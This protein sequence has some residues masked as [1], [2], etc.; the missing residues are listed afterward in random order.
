MAKSFTRS[1]NLRNLLSKTGCPETI[2]RCKSVFH[3]LI[4]PR[5]TGSLYSDITTLTTDNLDPHTGDDAGEDIDDGN[6]DNNNL[7]FDEKASTGIP[8][9]LLQALKSSIKTSSSKAQFLSRIH[10]KGLSYAVSS[11]HISNS[12]ILLKTAAAEKL[13]PLHIN[14]IF[15]IVVGGKVQTYVAAQGHLPFESNFQDPFRAYPVL[16][17]QLWSPRLGELR[18]F[19]VESIDSH[20]ASCSLIWDEV[21]AMVVLSLARVSRF[22]IYAGWFSNL[23]V[24]VIDSLIV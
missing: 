18:V 22:T 7:A 4:N 2:R 23:F 9:D 15:R 24:R 8:P 16:R 5:A 11:V 20:F 3:K 21:A 1:A 14:Y 12:C 10:I 13:V 17:A 6:G 19:P